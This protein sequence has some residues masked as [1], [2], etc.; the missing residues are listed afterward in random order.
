[1]NLHWLRFD[2]NILVVRVPST[3]RRIR[4]QAPSRT[5]WRLAGEGRA[6]FVRPCG[7]RPVHDSTGCLWR[8]CWKKDVTSIELV[9]LTW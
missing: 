1:M 8:P 7:D 2:R 6:S 4:R 5:P 9:S 3:P